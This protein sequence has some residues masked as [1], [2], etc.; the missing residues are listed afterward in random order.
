MTAPV[1]SPATTAMTEL[2]PVRSHHATPT[3]STIR[4]AA[5]MRVALRSAAWGSIRWST[6]IET[7]PT[8]E[9]QSPAMT[10]TMGNSIHLKG[11]GR[12]AP[13]AMAA[14]IEPT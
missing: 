7:T 11:P 10:T 12:V 5:A 9:A 13:M 1:T 2:R 3:V 8:A 4:T 14:T 6:L